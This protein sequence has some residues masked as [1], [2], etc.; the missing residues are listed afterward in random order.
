MLKALLLSFTLA[1]GLAHAAPTTDPYA[2]PV[3]NAI[4]RATNWDGCLKVQP[5]VVVL[6]TPLVK[7]IQRQYGPGIILYGFYIP[8]GK[9]IFAREDYPKETLE[10]IVHESIHYYYHNTHKV[11]DRC[12]S[13]YFARFFAA[14]ITGN[15]YD[16]TWYIRYECEDYRNAAKP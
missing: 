11:D 15:P 4:C 7:M 10:V 16:A 8:G 3:Q 13:E 12:E 14:K 2:N 9:Y 1:V 6:S 5:P